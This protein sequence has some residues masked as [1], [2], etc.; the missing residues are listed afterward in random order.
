M[1]LDQKLKIIQEDKNRLA[2][3]S[4]LRRH[5]VHIEIRGI[6]SRGHRTLS[7]L[8]SWLPL[9]GHLIDLLRGRTGNRR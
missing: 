4:D 9:A 7:H 6:W 1:F 3:C 8:A 2:I 5:L